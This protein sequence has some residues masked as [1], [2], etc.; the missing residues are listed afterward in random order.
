MR[1]QLFRQEAMDA[2]SDSLH[3]QAF[4]GPSATVK[5]LCVLLILWIAAVITFLC[6]RQYTRTVTVQGWL[7]P[8]EGITRLYTGNHSGTVSQVLVKEGEQVSTGQP[9]VVLHTDQQLSTSAALGDALANENLQ[10]INLLKQKTATVFDQF[11]QQKAQ[12]ANTLTQLR[13]NEALELQLR[14]L[15]NQKQQ[16]LA[17]K[18]NRIKPVAG[19]HIAQSD[20][21]TLFNEWLYAK[22]Q[23]TELDLQLSTNSQQQADIRHKLL[24]TESDYQQTSLDLKQQESQLLQN[25]A[26]FTHQQSTTIVATTAGV[27]NSLN[28][29]AGDSIFANRLLATLIPAKSTLQAQLMIPARSAGLISTDSTV[30]LRFDAFPYQKFGMHTGRLTR[31]SPGIHL[32][33]D[34]HAPYVSISEPVKIATAALQSQQINAYGEAVSL[35]PGMTFSADIAVSQRSLLEWLAEPLLTVTG[36]L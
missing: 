26:R 15:A 20:F 24:Q 4:V 29:K 19:I 2:Q 17:D 33:E 30:R 9:L 8:P 28:I 12:L 34:I 11:V 13:Q 21:D 10:Q 36:R 22:Q 18:V 3:S 16:R 27:V 14:Q 35:K 23:V 31:L 7:S 5:A 1:T 6:S 25:Q 32:P